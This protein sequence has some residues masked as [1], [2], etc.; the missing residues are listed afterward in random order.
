MWHDRPA[1]STIDEACAPDRIAIEEMLFRHRWE[2]SKCPESASRFEIPAIDGSSPIIFQVHF[3]IGVSNVGILAVSPQTGTL[4]G[5][6]RHDIVG[7][8]HREFYESNKQKWDEILACDRA[9][10]L[11]K[12]SRESLSHRY[13]RTR[14]YFGQ[15]EAKNVFWGSQ[16]FPL[17]SCT[18]TFVAMA[19]SMSLEDV[20]RIDARRVLQ[21]IDQTL[22]RVVAEA[23]NPV[24]AFLVEERNLF[25]NDDAVRACGFLQKIPIVFRCADEY[26]PHSPYTIDATGKNA[27]PWI[28]ENGASSIRSRPR[29]LPALRDDTLSF[30]AL[31]PE[32]QEA[33]DELFQQLLL[34][35]SPG[36]LIVLWGFSTHTPLNGA[37]VKT[38]DPPV[39]NEVHLSAKEPHFR[40]HIEPVEAGDLPAGVSPSRSPDVSFPR[41]VDINRIAYIFRGDDLVKLL[42][43]Q[44]N[45]PKGEIPH[46][47]IKNRFTY[48]R[49]KNL[50]RAYDKIKKKA[51]PERNKNEIV[52]V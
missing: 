7:K 32:K 30:A 38:A 52:F 22:S 43:R 23:D 17:N 16:Y 27:I 15:E 26:L 45:D 21:E 34:Y 3:S 11:G 13:G 19:V 51:I 14:S 12:S 33:A 1:G 29:S 48:F 25:V 8:H 46:K 10:L 28:L 35:L 18:D 31:S 36:M 40:I 24:R 47:I 5:C 50:Y 42:V 2:A 6:Y 9:K 4:L 39:I 44:L 20:K 49:K 41:D 37:V